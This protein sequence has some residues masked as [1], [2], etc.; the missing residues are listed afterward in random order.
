VALA[1]TIFG[2]GVP[3]E[4]SPRLIKALL[5]AASTAT[6]RIGGQESPG[7]AQVSKI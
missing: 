4:G 3:P 5:D 2:Y 1:L 6:R 7:R